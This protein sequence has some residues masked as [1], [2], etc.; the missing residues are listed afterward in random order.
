MKKIQLN[1]CSL[2]DPTNSKTWSGTP[3][4]LYSELKKMDCLGTAFISKSSVNKYKRRLISLITRIYYTNSIDKERGFLHRYLN[5]KKVEYETAISNTNLTLHTG[6]LDLPFY[7]LPLNQKHYL[8]CDSTWNL[9]ASYSTD[10]KGYTKKLLKDAEKL[11]RKAYNQME[12][13][14]PISEYVKDN[15]VTHY[16]INPK[17]I[18]VVGT[19]LGVIKPYFGLKDYSNG[20]ILFAAKG[21][22]EDKG[23]PLV[24]EAFIIALR[25][26]PNLELIIVG[27]NEYAERIDLPNVKV[28]GFIP[29]EELQNIFNESS[30]FLMPAI[31]EPWGLVYL[32]AL[33]C[34]TPIVGLNRNSFPEISRKGEYG[35]GLIEADPNKLSEIL[36][37]AFSDCQKLEDIGIKGQEYCL[38]NFSWNNTVLKIINT[39]ENLEK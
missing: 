37:K 34:K 21:R 14:F 16:G 6:T 26:N 33:A 25:S 19:G 32:E 10:M 7:K 8:F 31:N 1:I 22:F 38:K 11:E 20:K 5:A 2:G 28:Y 27:Q 17:K 35:F 4:N 29:I 12:H 9:W 24:L 18:T 13:I 15:I 36:I 30:L 23:G 3:F 39:I